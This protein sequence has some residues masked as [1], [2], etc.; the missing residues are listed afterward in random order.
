MYVWN[1]SNFDVQ[2]AVQAGNAQT[3]DGYSFNQ[4]VTSGASPTFGTLYVN[5]D[6]YNNGV[7]EIRRD[8]SNAYLFPWGTGV[9]QCDR[10]Y[11][12]RRCDQS[13]CPRQ[14]QR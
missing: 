10:V 7:D 14:R 6:L 8:G 4:W 12:W 2:H 1:P 13:Q 11:R 3:T 5:G 9:W